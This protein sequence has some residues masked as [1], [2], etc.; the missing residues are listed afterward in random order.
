[1]KKTELLSPAGNLETLKVAVQNG[2]D[3]IYMAG[4]KFGARAFWLEFVIKTVLLTFLLLLFG[5]IMPK[6]YS[7]QDSL[8]FCRM[9]VNGI[10]LLRKIFWPL[11]WL[12]IA[13]GILAEK[14]VLETVCLALVSVVLE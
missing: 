8:K 1:M 13:S 11:E 9:S 5:E 4:K 7:R 10:L 2:A 6:I 3:A 14:V 12:L